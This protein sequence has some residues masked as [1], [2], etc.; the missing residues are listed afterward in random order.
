M[1]LRAECKDLTN[2]IKMERW[3]NGRNIEKKVSF[4]SK[5]ESSQNNQPAGQMFEP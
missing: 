2:F 4:T 1:V 5:N 3:H